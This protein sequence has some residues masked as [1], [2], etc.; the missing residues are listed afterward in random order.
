MRTTK[1][2]APSGRAWLEIVR[3]QFMESPGIRLTK[4]QV[5]RLCGLD[6]GACLDALSALVRDNFLR[7]KPDGHYLR[8]DQ[9]GL[10][11]PA[12]IRSASQRHAS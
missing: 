10:S 5:K 12:R 7:L 2:T 3:A 1:D 11:A 8:A 4:S 9:D 6:D